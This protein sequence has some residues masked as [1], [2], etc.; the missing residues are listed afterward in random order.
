MTDRSEE[1]GEPNGGT[2]N[3]RKLFKGEIY[4]ILNM[5]TAANNYSLCKHIV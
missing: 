1:E 4:D 2:R 3:V 5:N